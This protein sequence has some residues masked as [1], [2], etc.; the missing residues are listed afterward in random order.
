MLMIRSN[1]S[2]HSVNGVARDHIPSVNSGVTSETAG[3]VA[4]MAAD[5]KG[6]TACR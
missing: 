6:S 1:F 3:M 2:I 5:T 4:F